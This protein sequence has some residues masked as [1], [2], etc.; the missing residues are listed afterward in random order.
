MSSK[1]LAEDAAAESNTS[2]KPDSPEDL[3]T[4]GGEWFNPDLKYMQTHYHR[5]IAPLKFQSDEIITER[6]GYIDTRRQVE[7]I[8]NA[9][10][11]LVAYRE[12]YYDS[13]ENGNLPEGFDDPTRE[14]GYDRIDA[15]RDAQRSAAAL[16]KQKETALEMAQKSAREHAKA[17]QEEQKAYNAWKEAKAR[18]GGPPDASGEVKKA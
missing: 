1:K 9:G 11:Q 15:Y 18:A 16:K 13:D 3:F 14:P 8:I 4:Y 2:V 10:K 7:S 12:A 5:F 17:A 6:A